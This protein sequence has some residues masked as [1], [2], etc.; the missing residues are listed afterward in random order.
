MTSINFCFEVHQPRRLKWF[1]PDT[2]R[3]VKGK[4]L[5]KYYF[6]DD[7]NEIIFKRV[8]EKCYFPT[9]TLFLNLIDKF[10]NQKKKFKITYSLTGTFLEQCEK[11]NKNLLETFKQLAETGCVEFLD[12]TYYHSLCGLFAD[13]ENFIEEVKMHNKLMKEILNYSPKIFRNTELLYNNNIA[14]TV[15]DLGYKGI[16]AE[17]IERIL[18]YWRS[19]NFLYKAKDLN[20]RVFLR[21]YRLSDDIAFRFSFKE[22]NEF[23]LTSDKYA[24]W[25]S[26]TNGEIINLYMDYETFGEHQWK[27]TGIFEFLKYLPEEI[28]K[29][30]NLEFST[31][32]ECIEKY[33]PVGEIDVPWHRTISWADSERDHTAWLGNHNQLLCF[34]NIQRLY[35]FTEKI[36]NKDTKEIY[37]RI[38]RFLTT[39]DHF[40]YMSTKNISD[41][42]IHN[43]FSNRNNPYDAAMNFLSII[44]DLGEK[45][46][47]ELIDEKEKEIEISNKKIYEKR[48]EHEERRIEEIFIL[49]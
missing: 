22:W 32:S 28:F 13:K 48:N 42:A 49:K 27:E 43:Y 19:Q 14:K 20:L 6:D 35:Y 12:E 21:N 4:D 39:S 17:G 23:P 34:S 11:Y 9:N 26:K 31:P 46:L 7:E 33:K 45:I 8:A 38:L 10:K 2:T 44:S 40:H 3:N 47:L 5:E 25:L 1:W 41:Q 30:E 24:I 36:E 37:K 29:Y 16:F 18:D 15:E